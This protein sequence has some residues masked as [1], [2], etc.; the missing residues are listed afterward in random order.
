MKSCKEITELIATD[1]TLSFKS[2]VELRLH[3]M[4]CKHCHAYSEQLKIMNL[5]YKKVFKKIS[6]TNQKHLHQL[7]NEVIDR[8][9]NS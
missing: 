9:K 1:K 2:K 6:E 8:L 4:I 7:E 5:Q 3:L